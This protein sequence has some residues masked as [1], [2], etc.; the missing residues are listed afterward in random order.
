[1]DATGAL[2]A[3]TNSTA[4]P[5][6][7]NG[8]L[9]APWVALHPNGKFAYVVN[10]APNEN[11]PPPPGFVSVFSINSTTG[12]LTKLASTFAT[13]VLPDS[14]VIDPTGNCA[15]VANLNYVHGMPVTAGSISAYTINT[16]TG[17]LTPLATSYGTELS[18]GSVTVDGTGKYVF[19]AN[20][21]SDSISGYAIQA[22]SGN[23]A[24]ALTSIGQSFL[25]TGT[26][27]FYAHPAPA[28]IAASAATPYIFVAE[29]RTNQITS[30]INQS[31]FLNPSIG[32][33][34]LNSNF[35]TDDRPVALALD[36][37]GKYLYAAIYNPNGKSGIDVFKIGASGGLTQVGALVAADMAPVSLRVD[38]LGRFLYVAN[39]DSDDVSIFKINSDGSLTAEGSQSNT[40]GPIA[41]AI[42]Q[43]G[44]V[45]F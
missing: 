24:C 39:D 34:L 29:N 5:T 21:N 11:L 38:P 30:L 31:G 2:T 35:T 26:N 10:V 27:S 17:V 3:V 8:E 25:S 4:L 43:A 37:H 14:I 6:S 42:W 40:G 32:G 44:L 1:M 12:A 22:T 33:N 18:P 45:S 7:D 20:A 13:G 16:N 15:Y 36:P 28:A 19:A 41:I 9:V 23:N